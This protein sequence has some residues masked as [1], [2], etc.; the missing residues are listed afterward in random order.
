[1]ILARIAKQTNS[2]NKLPAQVTLPNGLTPVRVVDRLAHPL[3]HGARR[4]LVRI[5]TARAL[6]DAVEP[7]RD[8]RGHPLAVGV[9]KNAPTLHPLAQHVFIVP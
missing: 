8:V 2:A 1:M 9:P 6:A 5:D 7:V 3:Q 4:G